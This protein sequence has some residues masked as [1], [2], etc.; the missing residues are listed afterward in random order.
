MT[1]FILRALKRIR[2]ILAALLCAAFAGCGVSIKYSLSGASIPPDART[3]SVAYFPAVNSPAIYLSPP[4]IICLFRYLYHTLFKYF[5]RKF[6]AILYIIKD[7]LTAI[8][9]YHYASIDVILIYLKIIVNILSIFNISNMLLY[10]EKVR[11]N[12]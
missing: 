8:H 1:P 9:H 5:M 3:F 11:Y 12:S 10:V 2:I 6:S 7:C 4:F